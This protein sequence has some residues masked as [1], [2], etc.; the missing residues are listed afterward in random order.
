MLKKESKKH[1]NLKQSQGHQTSDD[2]VDQKQD[3]NHAKFERSCSYGVQ[4]KASIKGFFF[5]MRKCVN[6]SREHVRKK[7]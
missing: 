1:V 2:N 4:E 7:K 3:Y 6:Y 5:Q